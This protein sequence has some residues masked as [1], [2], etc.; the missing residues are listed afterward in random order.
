MENKKY[1]AKLTHLF[2]HHSVAES[3]PY[4]VLDKAYSEYGHTV[5]VLA[6]YQ[7]LT[8]GR[9]LTRAMEHP[10]AL[11]ETITGVFPPDVKESAAEVML[12]MAKADIDVLLAFVQ[13]IVKPFEDPMGQRIPFL[14]P[15]GDEEDVCPVCGAEVEYQGD[16]DID[17]N[18]GT[19]V[20]WEC[21]VC[22]AF[23]KALYHDTF[24][25]HE[26]VMD[27]NGDCVHDRV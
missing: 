4:E 1:D 15:N 5:C 24:L 14:H 17:Y 21:P 20:S 18:D 26:A 19:E 10:A 12:L 11:V 6:L 27:G 7:L 13:R 9:K 23:G 22:K 2:A 16:R 25:Q 3:T 8:T